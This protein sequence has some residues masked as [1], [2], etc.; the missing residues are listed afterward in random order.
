MDCRVCVPCIHLICGRLRLNPW[1]DERALTSTSPTYSN[2][3]SSSLLSH[4]ALIL[5]KKSFSI[6]C[7][8]K[9]LLALS[10][11]SE[12]SNKLADQ[13]QCQTKWQEKTIT[14]SKLVP[15]EYRMWVVQAEATLGVYELFVESSKIQLLRSMPTAYCLQSMPH[16]ATELM[17]GIVVMLVQEKRC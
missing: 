12:K 16:C 13:N 5:P 7:S 15:I 14:L 2:V 9:H 11:V 1:W 8:K 3:V 17:T 4:R 6:F 10:Q